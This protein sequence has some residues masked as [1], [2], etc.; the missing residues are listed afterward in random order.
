M[1]ADFP[2]YTS[3]APVDDVM[4]SSSFGQYW[5]FFIA[6][7]L[8]GFLP[9]Y[10][11]FAHL[12][13][14]SVSAQCP[15]HMQKRSL[16]RRPDS[17]PPPVLPPSW[18]PPFR[19]TEPYFCPLSFLLALLGWQSTYVVQQTEGQGGTRYPTVFLSI[20]GPS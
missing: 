5:L 18:S 16:P 20:H 10:S 6:I 1:L 17:G 7:I 8:G 11:L 4:L 14:Q 15:F 19:A 12:S 3:S 2:R 9:F 13:S